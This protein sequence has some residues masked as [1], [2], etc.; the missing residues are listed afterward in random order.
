MLEA[1]LLNV[2]K[3]IVG[4]VS[5]EPE[6]F[7]AEIRPHMVQEVVR[8]QLN[9]R[10]AGTANTKTRGDLAFSTRK[11]YRQKKTGRAR[12]GTRKSPLW[13]KGGTVFGPHPRDF[14]FRPPAAVRRGALKSCLTDIFQEER[15]IFLD[16]LA[17]AE[18]KTKLLESTL[19]PLGLQETPPALAARRTGKE[20]SRSALRRLR[21]KTLILTPEAD[22]NLEKSARNNPFLD[23]L[24]VD[25]LNCFDL[26]DHYFV[27]VLKDSLPKI[28]E[29][30]M[31]K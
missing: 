21:P 4:T 11:P 25:G 13:R 17:L 22:G 9:S 30:L 2:H 10:R 26:L 27:V 18:I 23:V 15:M 29:R 16:E 24:R 19:A 7:Q 28:H 1:K 31:R 12:A 20:K 14:G 6:I 5:L 8:A 3:E